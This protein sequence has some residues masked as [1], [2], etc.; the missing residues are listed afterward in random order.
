MN[1]HCIS[2]ESIHSSFSDCTWFPIIVHCN[3]KPSRFADFASFKSTKLNTLTEINV[4][5]ESKKAPA[6]DY[7]VTTTGV[8]RLFGVFNAISI[9]ATTYGN[10]IIPEIQV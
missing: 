8:N 6:K 2:S 5:G 7:A 3:S 1:D 4:A 10:G 9:I